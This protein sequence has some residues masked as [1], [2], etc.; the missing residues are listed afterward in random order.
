MRVVRLKD[1]AE[2]LNVPIDAVVK[3]YEK[4]LNEGKLHG[5]IDSK[6]EEFICY[7]PEEIGNLTKILESKRILLNELAEKLEIKPE[8]A[9]LIIDRLLEKG[10]IT[11]VF[12]QNGAFVPDVVL[13]NLVIELLEENTNIEIHEISDKLAVP[14]KKVRLVIEKLIEQIMN[15]VAPYRQIRFSDLHHDIKLSESLTVALLKRL[16]SEGRIVGSL[17]MVNQILTIDQALKV[18]LE[19]AELREQ[20]IGGQTE[21]P[22]PSNAWYLAPLFLG[23]IG[24]LLGYIAV[25]GEDKSM[26]DD[27]LLAGIIMTFFGVIVSVAMYLWWLSRIF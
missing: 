25:K 14:E 26:A 21:V 3:T 12:T 6:N 5:I 9:Y 24:G 20:R 11:G 1:E 19:K 16:I 18:A 23:F 2:R 15:T 27:L 22:K 10:K 7:T 4:L 8:Q 13:R 17:D